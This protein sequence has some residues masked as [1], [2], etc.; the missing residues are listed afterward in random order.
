MGTM[1]SAG[2]QVFPS[3]DSRTVPI[4]ILHPL[5][6]TPCT[7]LSG[8]LNNTPVSNQQLCTAFGKG[9]LLHE[10]RPSYSFILKIKSL[11]A[12]PYIGISCT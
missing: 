7:N 6:K 2:G 12:T 8:F 9:M 3:T 5:P 1:M 11:Q 10:T 4:H